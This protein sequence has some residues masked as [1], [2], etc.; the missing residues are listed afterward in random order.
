M[1][2]PFRLWPPIHGLH[3][4]EIV[5][6]AFDIADVV[7]VRA[8]LFGDLAFDVDAWLQEQL[9]EVRPEAHP[10]DIEIEV[11]IQP[12]Q[13]ADVSVL[14]DLILLRVRLQLLDSFGE[15]THGTVP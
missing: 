7:E 5:G 9:G 10:L 1:N 8:D 14:Y 4:L 3:S 12:L 6:D 15:C 2:E 11:D 13:E